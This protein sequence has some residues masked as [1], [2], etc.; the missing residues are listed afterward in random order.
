MRHF[1][2]AAAALT[3]VAAPMVASAQDRGRRE[4]REDRRELR[5]DRREYR[6]DR[7]DARRDGYVSER[8]RR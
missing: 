2:L 4:W 3:V 6:E 5:E 7:R 1:L 8:E